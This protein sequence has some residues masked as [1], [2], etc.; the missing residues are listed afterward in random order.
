MLDSAG[1][2][3]LPTRAH[4]I[5]GPSPHRAAP[6]PSSVLLQLRKRVLLYVY[7]LAS[8]SVLESHLRCEPVAL[9]RI[10]AGALFKQVQ[11]RQK[12]LTIIKMP[13]SAAG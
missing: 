9:A 11:K 4:D 12:Q 13:A 10:Q 8:T 1:A 5:P 2:S 6:L 3:T 7:P